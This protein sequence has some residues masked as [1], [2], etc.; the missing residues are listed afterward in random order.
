[1][2]LYPPLL[3]WICP[4]F[5]P[6]FLL[7]QI[8]RHKKIQ[9]HRTLQNAHSALLQTVFSTLTSCHGLCVNAK[10][11]SAHNNT[12]AKSL[13]GRAPQNWCSPLRKFQALPLRNLEIKEIVNQIISVC[14]NLAK[15][16]RTSH[17][18]QRK[19]HAAQTRQ[20]ITRQQTNSQ[21]AHVAWKKFRFC[22]MNI[23]PISWKWAI[24]ILQPQL[25]SWPNT[26]H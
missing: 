1:M 26:P 12:K 23:N 9:R 2:P 8:Q 18:A 21:F 24:F 13:P 5:H 7:Y 14:K 19:R 20:Q 17:P 11:I 6:F 3:P 10:T 4:C 15:K 25:H 22:R 16:W